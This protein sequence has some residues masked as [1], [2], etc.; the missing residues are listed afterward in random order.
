MAIQKTDDKTLGCT[1]WCWGYISLIYIQ[2][3]SSD[4]DDPRLYTLTAL[5]RRGVPSAAINSFCAG[6][7]VTGA[8]GAVDPTMLD[9]YVRDALN[10]TAPR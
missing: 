1:V 9:A 5:R 10:V 3:S 6:L 8:L 2:N 7:G 4:W